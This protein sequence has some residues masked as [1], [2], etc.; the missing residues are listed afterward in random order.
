MTQ[1]PN[2]RNYIFESLTPEEL[3]ALMDEMTPQV[4][5]EKTYAEMIQDFRAQAAPPDL[6]GSF[7]QERAH[8]LK[9]AEGTQIP[10]RMI[11]VAAAD[12]DD[13]RLKIQ[14]YNGKV[15]KKD[16]HDGRDGLIAEMRADRISGFCKHWKEFLVREL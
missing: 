2:Q 4:P 5:R 15:L 9:A 16:H 13:A 12:M 14:F 11:F 8:D 6:L 10:M 1:N 3:N 7:L